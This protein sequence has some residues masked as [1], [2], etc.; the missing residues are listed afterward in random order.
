MNRIAITLSIATAFAAGCGVTHLLRPA[1]AAEN[2]TAQVISTGDLE[3][4]KLSPLNAGGMRNKMLVS[5]DGVT[6]AIQDGSPPKHLHA[7]A[8][9]IQYIL[10]GTGTIWLGDKEVTVKPGDLVVIPKGT[11]H[12]GTKPVGR[13]IKAIAIKTPPQAPDDT[14]ILN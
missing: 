14:K 11:P 10:E 3:G 1:L 2:I 8:N 13:T 7:N 9:E 12:G 5:A 6:I 4:D